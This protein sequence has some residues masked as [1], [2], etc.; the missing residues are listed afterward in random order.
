MGH[1][2]NRFHISPWIPPCSSQ[3]LAGGCLPECSCHGNRQGLTGQGQLL[4]LGTPAWHCWSWWHLQ[5]PAWQP[6]AAQLLAQ[7]ATGDCDD[8]GAS[9]SGTARGSGAQ[10]SWP[11]CDSS[12]ARPLWRGN[13]WKGLSPSSTKGGHKGS[14]GGSPGSGCSPNPAQLG[15]SPPELQVFPAIPPS[16]QHDC[17]ASNNPIQ[18]KAEHFSFPSLG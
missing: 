5:C 3:S 4:V 2:C 15:C 12:S 8:G 10:S 16:H 7:L 18:S 14:L 17:R 9:A 1:T 13:G 6:G 11:C